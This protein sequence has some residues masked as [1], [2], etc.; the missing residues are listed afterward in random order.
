[1]FENIKFQVDNKNAIR[2]LSGRS[3]KANASRNFIAV[4]AIALTTILFTVLFTVGSGMVENIQR[5]TMRQ[6]GGDGMAYLKYITD[7]Q[8]SLIHI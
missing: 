2:R 1:M 4:A 7:E 3:L 5:Q 8:L 6:A